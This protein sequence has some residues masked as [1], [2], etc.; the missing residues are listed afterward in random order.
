ME[1]IFTDKRS[2]LHFD[3]I[4]KWIV[5]NRFIYIYIYIYIYRYIYIYIYVVVIV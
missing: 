2:S 3:T 1:N 4:Y 5:N